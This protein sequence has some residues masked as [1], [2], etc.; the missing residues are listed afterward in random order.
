MQGVSRS[1]W[2]VALLLVVFLVFGTTAGWAARLDP[3]VGIAPPLPADVT[4]QARLNP[5]VGAPAPTSLMDI[6]RIW[7]QSRISIPN[8]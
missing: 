7:W 6:I 3:P 8:G 5:P 2:R 1:A 4:T